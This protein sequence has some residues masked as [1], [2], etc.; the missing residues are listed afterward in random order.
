MT[1]K[2]QLFVRI[3]TNETIDAVVHSDLWP[4]LVAS[5][6]PTGIAPAGS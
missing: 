2:D 6:G 3:S 1:K 5:L 4:M